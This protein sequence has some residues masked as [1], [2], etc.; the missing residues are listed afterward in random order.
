M[1]KLVVSI[2]ASSLMLASCGSGS[3]SENDTNRELTSSN[4]AQE[5]KGFMLGGMYFFQGF[6]GVATVESQL[7][8]SDDA[9]QMISDYS[10][11]FVFPFESSQ[12][13]DIKSMFSEMWDIHSE[14][15]LTK[16]IEK[17]MTVKD[18]KNPHKAWDYARIVNNVCLGVPV[19]Y[20]TKDKAKT[21]VAETLKL[22]EKDFENWEVFLKDFNEG[23]NTWD[24]AAPDKADFDKITEQMLKNP[25]GL[26]KLI[27][28]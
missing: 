11:Y 26:Y 21:I 16:S 20:I 2:L 9:T 22:A 25:K 6:G 1:K 28:L 23:R 13:S 8:N 10:Q 4:E 17:L 18:P 15:D 3:E 12:A 27:E 7:S 14:A 5:L 24:P 19:G